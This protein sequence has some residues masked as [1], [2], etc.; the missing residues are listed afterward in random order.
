MHIYHYPTAKWKWE[1]NKTKVGL[2]DYLLFSYI[3]RKYVSSQNNRV[4]SCMLFGC[5]LW[6]L[7]RKLKEVI[8]LRQVFLYF[9]ANN[10]VLLKKSQ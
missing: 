6:I 9:L 3:D 2:S 10:L 1:H 5:F 7:K 8:E 4:Q